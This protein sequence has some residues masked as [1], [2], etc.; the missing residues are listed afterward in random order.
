M[1]SSDLIYSPFYEHNFENMNTFFL[2]CTR[3][4]EDTRKPIQHLTTYPTSVFHIINCH[5]C[6]KLH[7]FTS[8]TV[9]LSFAHM[10]FP[11]EPIIKD[12]VHKYKQVDEDNTPAYVKQK[13][14][15][16]FNNHINLLK[17]LDQ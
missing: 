1:S 12:I 7:H 17:L 2:R 4:G 16:L 14:T 8:T 5:H 9:S 15:E 11:D 6:G 3:C 10:F 13:A